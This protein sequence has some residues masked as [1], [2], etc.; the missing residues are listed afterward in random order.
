MIVASNPPLSLRITGSSTDPPPPPERRGYLHRIY[1]VF[2]SK[3]YL[4]LLCLTRNLSNA[5][6][7]FSKKGVGILPPPIFF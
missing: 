3:N 1:I 6:V 4:I 7:F 5:G 2:H